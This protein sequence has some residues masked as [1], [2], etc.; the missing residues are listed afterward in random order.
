[1]AVHSAW[2]L[3]QRRPKAKEG[4]AYER[5]DGDVHWVEDPERVGRQRSNARVALEEDD[6]PVPQ[7]EAFGL[8]GKTNNAED[9]EARG[10]RRRNASESRQ[11]KAR[12]GSTERSNSLIHR[13]PPFLRLTDRL[14]HRL[15]ALEQM[16]TGCHDP[17]RD[18]I[19]AERHEEHLTIGD[20]ADHDQRKR[21]RPHQG[22]DPDERIPE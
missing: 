19:D 2:A 18:E 17:Q 16:A 8:H 12:F 5:E 6:E 13:E 11:G 15:S 1:M 22:A 10:N 14:P 3:A 9:E 21:E 7:A 4:Q 20:Q